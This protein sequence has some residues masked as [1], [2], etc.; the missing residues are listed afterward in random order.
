MF[1]INI[2]NGLICKIPGFDQIN[3][4]SDEEL[5]CTTVGLQQACRFLGWSN[6]IHR[7]TLNENIRAKNA[8][9]FQKVANIRRG[10]I[11]GLTDLGEQAAQMAIDNTANISLSGDP[12][13]F[14]DR[15]VARNLDRRQRY[16]LFYNY[17]VHYYSLLV[18]NIGFRRIFIKVG[19]TDRIAMDDM[20]AN[21]YRIFR[22]DG[23]GRFNELPEIFRRAEPHADHL[24]YLAEQLTI[25]NAEDVSLPDMTIT[26]VGL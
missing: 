1:K 12:E 2:F 18:T 14:H 15:L 5:T 16:N 22:Q 17:L 25:S 3:A 21:I 26:V 6:K 20:T 13:T 7:R 19:M 4:I 8:Y 11:Q 23:S 9:D 24:V 10:F